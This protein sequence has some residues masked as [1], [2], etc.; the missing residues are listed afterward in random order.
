MLNSWTWLNQI[1]VHDIDMDQYIYIY[2]LG[3]SI[4]IQSIVI[5]RD[6]IKH[7]VLFIITKQCKLISR[8]TSGLSFKA[9]V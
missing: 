6:V 1:V 8:K 9:T 3:G 7:Y 2:S 5:V 4:V